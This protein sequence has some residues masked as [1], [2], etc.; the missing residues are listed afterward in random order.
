VCW[1]WDVSSKTFQQTDINLAEVLWKTFH[2]RC[3]INIISFID[4]SSKMF[5][6]RRFIKDVSSKAFNQ[7]M[8]HRRRFIY[9]RFIKDIYNQ[10][11]FHR[12]H[13]IKGRFIEGC[14][15]DGCYID[16]VTS[17]TL[18]RRRYWTFH[19]IE[20]DVLPTLRECQRWS[21]VK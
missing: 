20:P 2:R 10:R 8:S 19:F 1:N 16:D 9:R 11:T 4:V 13:L 5:H 7:R 6:Q 12:I 21:V 3:F 18:H 17:T 14:L 15:I